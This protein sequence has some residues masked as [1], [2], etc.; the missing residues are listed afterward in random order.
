MLHKRH[1]KII[2]AVIALVVGLVLIIVGL[3]G[4]NISKFL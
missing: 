3:A 2:A 1:H 4:I